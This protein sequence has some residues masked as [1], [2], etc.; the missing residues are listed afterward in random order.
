MKLDSFTQQI[1]LKKIDRLETLETARHLR[2]GVP[3]FVVE[4]GQYRICFDEKEK[5][6][7]ILFAGNHKQYEKWISEGSW[8]KN[9]L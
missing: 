6:R 4:A 3:L 1:L 7:L 5:T 2:H 8:K 9:P